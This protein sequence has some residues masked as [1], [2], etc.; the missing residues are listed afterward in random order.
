MLR[1]MPTIRAQFVGQGGSGLP[2]DRFVN[3]FHFFGGVVAYDAAV[4]LIH[5]VLEDFYNTNLG[6]GV[7]IGARLSEYVSRSAQIRYY[8]LT[9][10]EPRVPRIEPITLPAPLLSTSLPEEV[11][12]CISLRGQPP[13]TARRRGRLYIGPL[14]SSAATDTTTTVPSRVANAAQWAAQADGLREG[15]LAIDNGCVWSIRSTVP[16]QNFVTIFGG[17][18]DDA[19]DIQR[20]RGPGSTVRTDWGIPL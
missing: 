10:A 8:D 2:E 18:V 16:A 15:I 19:L 11:A 14:I 6:T 5:P 9:T 17:W 4:D 7:A 13:V 1:G 20:R 12:I 3:T